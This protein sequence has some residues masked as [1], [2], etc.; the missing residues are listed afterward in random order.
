[1]NTRTPL[2]AS[3]LLAAS[4]VSGTAHAEAVTYGGTLIYYS[5]LGPVG[6]IPPYPES[7]WN[8]AIS[9]FV[10][11]AAG[12]WGVS[13]ASPTLGDSGLNWTASGGTLITTEGSY[14]LDI[15]TGVV[16]T[17]PIPD[18][19]VLWNMDGIMYFTVGANEIAGVINWS[20]M[21]TAY[22]KIVNVWAVND[23]GSL[24]V[25]RS[26][27]MESGPILGKNITLD[28]VPSA[29][30]EPKAYAMFLAGFGLVG[31]MVQRRK[32]ARISH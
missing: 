22:T 21:S 28:L 19:N 14:A 7:I 32:Q 8:P 26:P 18:F 30:P 1:M 6:V 2:I 25:V 23:D 12:T 10:D 3:T 31:S 16:T 4:L 13:P 9:A 29:V 27:W 15:T 24:T 17:T 20:L 5:G 11:Q